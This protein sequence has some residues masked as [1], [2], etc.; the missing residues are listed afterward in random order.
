M[1]IFVEMT[2]ESV[3]AL[4]E[5][6]ELLGITWEVEAPEIIT[7]LIALNKSQKLLLEMQGAPSLDGLSE[8]PFKDIPDDTPDF[9]GINE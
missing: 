4:Q 8:D 7:R 3:K 2:L 6:K 1:K 5:A 9:L